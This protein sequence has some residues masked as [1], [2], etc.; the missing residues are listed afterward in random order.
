[1]LGSWVSAGDGWPEAVNPDTSPGAMYNGGMKQKFTAS[2]WSEGDWYVAQCI[3]VDVASQGETEQE[4]L[5]NLKEALTLHFTP[6]TASSA[7][8]LIPFEIEI[9]AA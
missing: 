1:M 8:K 9:A 3:E 5:D 6:P 4:A 2:V 7:P